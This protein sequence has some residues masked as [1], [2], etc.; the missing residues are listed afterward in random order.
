MSQEISKALGHS[1][2]RTTE[3]LLRELAHDKTE[4][5]NRLNNLP[6]DFL[7]EEVT[8]V[9]FL[10]MCGPTVDPGT[11]ENVLAACN[12]LG[13]CRRHTLTP[14]S[15]NK[16]L[17]QVYGKEFTYEAFLAC[18]PAPTRDA[19]PAERAAWLAARGETT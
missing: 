19:T 2:C 15:L 12:L 1:S 7:P 3:E 11:W 6:A 16:C 17:R 5:E 9:R 18:V 14:A 13:Q 4:R 8:M 10:A